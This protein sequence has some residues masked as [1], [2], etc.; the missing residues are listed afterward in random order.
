MKTV[1]ISPAGICA[2]RD[3]DGS[4]GSL[5]EIVDGYIQYVRLLDLDG[6]LVVNEEGLLLGLAPNGI[7]SNLAGELIVGTACVLGPPT[8]DGEDTDITED[9]TLALRAVAA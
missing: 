3:V 4:L 1:V 7:A 5:Q 6:V 9:V 2:E 8:A